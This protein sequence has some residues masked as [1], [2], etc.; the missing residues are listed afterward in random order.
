[1]PIWITTGLLTIWAA[2]AAAQAAPAIAAFSAA[3]G[4]QPPPPWRAVG[5]PGNKAPLT[6]MDIAEA[7]GARV[8]RLQASESYGALVHE[9]PPWRPPE[10]ASLQ[11]RWRLEQPLAKPDLHRKDGDDA[12]LKVCVMFDMALDGLPFFE[13]TLLRLARV[14]SGELL[15][16]ATIC[17]VWDITLARDMALPNPY[18]RRLRY[19]VVDGADSAPG[20]W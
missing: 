19:L 10:G 16:A 6:L 13:R 15:P 4:T 11:W 14:F 3:A 18:S 8:L 2:D 7:D 1:M 12:A 20:A 9:V 17:Y 5:L